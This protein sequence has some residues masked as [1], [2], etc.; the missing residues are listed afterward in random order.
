MMPIGAYV[1]ICNSLTREEFRKHHPH[2]VL[3]HEAAA[4]LQPAGNTESVTIDRLI[5]RPFPGP[6]AARPGAFSADL[7][8]TVYALTPPRGATSGRLTIGCSSRCELQINDE[9]LSKE[10]A[11]FEARRGGYFL[12][13]NDSASGTQVDDQPLDVLQ[14]VELS[15]GARIA[16][17]NVSLTFLPA[18]DFY[19][20]V[21]RL[22]I[23]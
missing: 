5:D 12:C 15:P 21:R 6:H 4:P 14:W 19:R 13:D 20:L 7:L 22:F 3:L 23:D 2:P 18:D 17:G 16:L 10:H 9:S 8:Y 11:L 1:N